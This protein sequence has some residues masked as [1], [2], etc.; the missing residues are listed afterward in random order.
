M[1]LIEDSVRPQRLV[2]AP[3]KP[4][5][6]P[7]FEFEAVEFDGTSGYVELS[8]IKYAPLAPPPNKTH[9]AVPFD[10]NDDTDQGKHHPKTVSRH[11][12]LVI[13]LC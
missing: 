11:R 6:N 10:I 9:Y 13:R 3:T 7:P 1:R 5:F 8:E 2:L 4:L 12:V